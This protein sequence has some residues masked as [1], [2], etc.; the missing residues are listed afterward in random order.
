[1][2]RRGFTLVEL[3]VVIGIIAV[4]ISL[5]LPALNKVREQAKTVTCMSN[6]RQLGL[7]MA[8]YVN[9]NK[10]YPS[11][12]WPEALNP[13][14][15]GT[16]LGTAELPDTGAYPASN[17][18]LTQV[19]PLRLI[20]CPS[21]PEVAYNNDPITLTYAINGVW[22]GASD[23]WALLAR[24]GTASVPSARLPRIRPTMIRHPAEF[25]LLTEY[26]NTKSPHQS[27]WAYH[28]SWFRLFVANQFEFLFVHNNGK[29]SN[30]LFADGHVVTLTCKPNGVDPYTGYKRLQDGNDSLFNYDGGFKRM[31]ADLPSKYLN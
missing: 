14:L 27:A 22:D 30:V 24:D 11:S 26:W 3:L 23:L 13:Y 29:G 10:M 8:M 15:K 20:H 4:L 21:V 5:L 16:L 25:G 7:A 18:L 6:M 9:E 28:S 12:W 1:M 19:A 17:V 2:K 31:G